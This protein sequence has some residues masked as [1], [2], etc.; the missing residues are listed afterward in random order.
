MRLKTWFGLLALSGSL[1]GV[2]EAATFV[3][4]S[5]LD[6]VDATPGDGLCLT[7]SS[8][9]TLRAAVMEANARAGSDVIDLS[10]MDDPLEPV[11]LSLEGVDET[12]SATP[13]GPLACAAV[14]TPDASRGDLDIVDDVI[15]QGAGP[16]RTIIQWD[17]QGLT[18]PF[19]GDRIFHVQAP[20]GI[21]IGT[22]EFRD[23]AVTRGSV[24][25]IGDADPDSPYN[26]AVT[27]TGETQRVTQ[28]RR[29]GGG[30]A[31]GDGAAVALQDASSE[32]GGSQRP[33]G[34]GHGG[35]EGEEEVTGGITE[36]TLERVAVIGNWSGS[37]AGGL[38]VTA[39]TTVVDSIF[40][41]NESGANGGG[42][43]LD[44]PTTITG[45]LVGASA[46]DVVYPSGPVD[47]E[48]LAGNSAENGGGL[49]ATGAHTSAIEASALNGNQATG[50]GAIAG[51]SLVTLN[52]VNT[53]ISGNSATDVGGGITTNGK[54]NLG[55]VT[56]ANNTSASDA[57]GGG[58][59]LN[60]FGRGS[61]TFYNSILANN[62]VGSG[63]TTRESN[64]GCTG[65]QSAC[66]PG[67]M[68]ST[69]FNL[70]DEAS[71]TCALNAALSDLLNTDPRLGPLSFRGGRTEVH[72]LPSVAAGDGETS[73]AVDAADDTR[74]PNNDQRGSLRPDDG[75]LNGT[76]ACDIGAYERFIARTDLHLQN[77]NAPN[78]AR[79]GRTFEIQ[80]EAHNDDGNAVAP[81]V[82]I[83]SVVDAGNG[84]V[85]TDVVPS[86]G[87]CTI[88]DG[89]TVNCAVGDLAIGAIA[90]ATLTVS[91][92][93]Q[94]KHT[95]T[96]TV[97]QSGA[98][99]LVDTVA[100]NNVIVSDVLVIGTSDVAITG[101]PVSATVD[102]GDE[103]G[104]NYVVT[105]L[106]T[107]L[108]TNVRA[109]LVLP[110][111]MTFVSATTDVGGPCTA[112]NGEVAC[113]IGE[114]A[115]DATAN[116]QVVATAGRAG[117]ISFSASAA[118][119]QTDPVLENNLTT[120]DVTV[121]ANADLGMTLTTSDDRVRLKQTFDLALSVTNNGPQPATDLVVTSTLPDSVSAVPGA[122]CTLT[123]AALRCTSAALA[124]GA[125]Q[126]F[127][128]TLKAVSA[129]D[130]TISA[131]A[132]AA[133]NDPVATNNSA[134]VTFE[135][136]RSGG[137]GC[138]YNP[139]GPIDPTLPGL[140]AVA[141]LLAVRRARALARANRVV[142]DK[143]PESVLLEA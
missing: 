109:G 32:H 94:G 119:D 11:T 5:T 133:E 93:V 129:G 62:T 34:T 50:G 10:G 63:E 128:V 19:L 89:S 21:A 25:V 14:I 137:G 36:V 100:A 43:Y 2:A 49:F 141:L 86:S 38:L 120:A 82:E 28:F 111:D 83:A 74:C 69:G 47:A 40:S 26:C 139:G 12:F 116:V 73:P 24:G 44:S 27:G 102:Q 143:H 39:A 84:L 131:S 112:T 65:G 41:A 118:A 104:L 130:I 7:A 113:P 53:T 64:C 140:L 96:T 70:S 103:I 1:S 123:G 138:A 57:E 107:D 22:V 92:E 76:Y 35:S 85:I 134:S 37:D 55:N 105:N 20:A 122:G 54:A 97:S 114:L 59:G 87:T 61:Y 81:G 30:I 124:S 90:T 48:L 80:V 56:L 79:K 78:T 42:L 29:F 127:T 71:D 136:R 115:L 77:V 16:G 142:G 17:Q 9:C 31:I 46:S 110:V 15:V 108:A 45:S 135:A 3:V 125:T 66:P 72:P 68:V 58:G 33:G 8:A 52:I 18:P 117:L 13:D 75:D 99:E 95:L 88:T 60:A 126:N 101:G 91:P 98:P 132:A 106:G 67:R 51:R 23:L 6:G 121:V 4:D